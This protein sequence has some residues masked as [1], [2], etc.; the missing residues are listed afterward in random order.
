MTRENIA[1]E[2]PHDLRDADERLNAYGRWAWDRPS[3][4][5]CGS[6]EGHFRPGGGAV[7]ESRRETK[8]PGLS[9]EEAL[10]CQRALARVPDRERVVLCILYIPRKMPPQVQ[11]RLLQ[12][13]ARISRERH[14]HG[15]RMFDNL[16]RVLAGTAA[17]YHES[18][19][20][21][22]FAGT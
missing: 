14:L 19:T 7:L 16:H 22:T 6:A 21:A 10:L 20:S 13:P 17:R 9:A 3:A 12:I 8:M 11:L 2:V 4:R 15:L 5:R 18:R 1:A